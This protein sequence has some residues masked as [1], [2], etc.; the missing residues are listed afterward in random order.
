MATEHDHLAQTIRH[1]TR[2]EEMVMAQRGL[3]DRMVQHGHDTHW[4]STMLR[5]FE[6]VRRL[7]CLTNRK[8]SNPICGK[9]KKPRRVAG[10]GV[11]RPAATRAR[12][13]G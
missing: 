10:G 4:G 2:A 1:I 13:R 6:S 7:N 11:L 5:S 8:N 9:H 3:I 12:R